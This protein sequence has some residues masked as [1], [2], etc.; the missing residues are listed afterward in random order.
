MKTI[1]KAWIK[2]AEGDYAVA[3]REINQDKAVYDIVCYHAHQSIEKYMKALL[4][5]NGID[6]D[7]IHDLE[8]LSQK[9]SNII[10]FD[11]SEKDGFIWLTQF[12]IRVKYP[13]FDATKKDA[14]K[15]VSLMQQYRTFFRNFFG[16]DNN[17]FFPD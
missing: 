16:L 9:I 10:T 8:N 11:D 6:F 5:E 7:K 4:V 15:A 2:K 14:V 3:E 17:D 12:A 13:G 1:T